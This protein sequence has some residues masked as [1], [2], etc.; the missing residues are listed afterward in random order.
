MLLVARHR[1]GRLVALLA[2]TVLGIA[3]LDRGSGAAGSHHVLFLV[4][5]SLAA[6]AGSRLLAPGAALLGARRVAGPWWVTPAGRLAG[7]MVLALPILALGAGGILGSPGGPLPIL[8]LGAAAALQAAA[9]GALVAGLAPLTGATAAG[10]LGLGAAWLG[11]V[12]PSGVAE[13][14]GGWEYA[15]RPAVLLWNGLPLAWRAARWYEGA[16]SGDLLV[17][18]GWVVVG[19]ALAAW[20]VGRSW[21]GSSSPGPGA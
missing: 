20:A 16:F 5:G 21:C 10:T 2:V 12:P 8:R 14:L 6:V 17:L 11:S 13:L 7:A 15:Q 3:I 18:A 4:G 9:L 1:A 19:V